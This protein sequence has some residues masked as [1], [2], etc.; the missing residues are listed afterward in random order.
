LNATVEIKIRFLQDRAYPRGIFESHKPVHETATDSCTGKN[1]T[2]G[3]GD[4]NNAI[5]AA[6]G[7][8]C[9]PKRRAWSRRV[10]PG[11]PRS[12]R[13]RNRKQCP[14]ARA[15][16]HADDHGQWHAEDCR[17]T[18]YSV[19]D[20]WELPNGSAVGGDIPMKK[21]GGRTADEIVRA[22]SDD[23]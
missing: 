1:G 11:A 2:R 7:Y 6:V 20:E 12:N 10:G 16:L 3:H 21:F 22:R 14:L 4:A 5:L 13:N 18:L 9:M 23:N 17:V 15:W 8:N 19:F